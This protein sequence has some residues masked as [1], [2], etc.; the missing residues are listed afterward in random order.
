MEQ[1]ELITPSNQGAPLVSESAIQ[2]PGNMQNGQDTL[3][4]GQ[5]AS[6]ASADNP[7]WNILP[8]VLQN[9]WLVWLVVALIL[10]IR[11]I[12]IYQDFVKYIR[13]G[14]VE[15][16]DIDM[17]E[18][19]GKLVE[20]NKV[21]TIVG[22]YTNNLISSPLLIGFFRPCIVLP[23][24]DLPPADF[25]YTIL[26]ELAHYKRRDMFYKWLVQ[27]AVCVHW[28]NPLVYVMSR[29][30]GRAGNVRYIWLSRWEMP[31]N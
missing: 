26:H 28:F 30:V 15:V 25:Q 12:T 23:S 27:L 7:A 11:R 22:L 21:K 18:R 8:V 17:L 13:A 31:L 2:P 9:L 4:N 14:C 3:E 19:F 24:A 6:S 29:D 16:A 5:P 10:F 1:I 20:Q